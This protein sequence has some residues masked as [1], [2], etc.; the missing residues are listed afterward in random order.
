[1]MFKAALRQNGHSVGLILPK[2]RAAEDLN[3]LYGDSVRALIRRSIKIE[4]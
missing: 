2:V 4:P 1:M 3:R